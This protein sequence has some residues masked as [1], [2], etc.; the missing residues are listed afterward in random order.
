M[1]YKKIEPS[2]VQKGDKAP[3]RI[4]HEPEELYSDFL[5]YR[6]SVTDLSDLEW[7]KTHFVGRDGERVHEK[8]IIPM[9]IAGFCRW[10]YAKDQVMAR[11]YFFK[12][13][14]YF[15]DFIPIVTLIKDEIRE[16]H[17][18]G[19]MLGFYNANITAR[20]QGLSDKQ[21]VSNDIGSIDIQIIDTKAKK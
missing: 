21:E 12:T 15:Q 3:D 20:L 4:Y 1:G 5:E 9:S 19:G 7:R 10:K 13:K 18:I 14:D 8:S 16:Q 17:I 6:K 2:M 11:N